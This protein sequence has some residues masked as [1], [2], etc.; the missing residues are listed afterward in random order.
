MRVILIGSVGERDRLRWR[1]RDSGVS[2]AGEFATLALA[3]GSGTTAD[4]YVLATTPAAG[5]ATGNDEARTTQRFRSSSRDIEALTLREREV[6]EQLAEGLPNK[7]IAEALGISDQTVKFHVAQIT[8]KLGATNRTEA[9]RLAIQNGLI[10][11]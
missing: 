3:R 5:A 4:A 7:A 9:V 11:V 2:V 1:L 6:L 10:A 8:G